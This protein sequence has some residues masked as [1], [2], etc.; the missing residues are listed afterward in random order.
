MTADQVS[1]VAILSIFLIPATIFGLGVYT[2]WR[3]R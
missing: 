1:R 2:W 3:R